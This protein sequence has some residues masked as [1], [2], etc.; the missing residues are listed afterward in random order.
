MTIQEMLQNRMALIA[1][2]EVI[3]NKIKD[4]KRNMTVDEK[5][6]WDKIDLAIIEVEETIER[7]K[8]FEERVKNKEINDYKQVDFK[9]NQETH[10]TT[11]PR[12]EFESTGEFLQAIAR[13]S[14]P[15]GRF[16]GAGTIDP[17]LA[18]MN[19]APSG[20]SAN[21]P[22]DGGVLISPTRSNEIMQKVFTGGEL[23]SR[24]S[25]FEVGPYSDSLEVP[26]L[27]DGSRASGSRWGGLQAYREG[28]VDPATA[29]KTKFGLWE[30]R[31]SDIKALAYITERL[32]AD[33]PALE[34]FIMATMPDVFMYKLEEELITG[35]GAKQMKGLIGDAAVVS[36]AKETGQAAK[37]ILFENIINM[38]SRCWGRSRNR[39]QWYHNQDIEPQLL[40][41]TLNAGTGGVPLFL[42]PNGISGSP[43]ATLMGKPLI[44]VEQCETLGTVGDIMLA[45]MAEY[46]I[47]RKGG[48]RSL[49]SI[50]V[51]FI[52][53]EMTFKFNMRVNGKPKWKSALIPAKGA[54]NTLSPWVTLN[55]RG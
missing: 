53:D 43:Y 46:A 39:A 19:T 31:V 1:K 23:L 13:A 51:K 5:S 49:S 3:L 47:V 9:N 11:D 28:E 40:S 37:T 34:S 4:E 16:Q 17:R 35:D 25:T 18:Y 20:M 44:P 8:A 52:Y 30:C 12:N 32:L 50:H 42:P 24:C 48:L 10:Q 14:S 38:W 54:A 2:Q 27:D 21:V 15:S 6:E 29:S 41:M 45:D 22:S 26:Y 55:T 7:Q 33:A 36:I